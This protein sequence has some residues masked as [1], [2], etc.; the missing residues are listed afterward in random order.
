MESTY[1]TSPQERS[2]QKLQILSYQNFL[3]KYILNQWPAARSMPLEHQTGVHTTTLTRCPQTGED[4]DH[5]E[6]SMCENNVRD[7]SY[8]MPSHVP[9]T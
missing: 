9:N 8:H 2:Q 5:I 4:C 1:F 7:V 3:L 6:V